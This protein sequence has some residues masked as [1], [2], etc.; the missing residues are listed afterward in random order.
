MTKEQIIE[1]ITKNTV[2]EQD[3]F[4]Y[5]GVKNIQGFEMALEEKIKE[6]KVN[7]EYINGAFKF[8]FEA[9]EQEEYNPLQE[10]YY[11]FSSLFP[12]LYGISAEEI[13]IIVRAFGLYK[14]M[15]VLETVL[16]NKKEVIYFKHLYKMYEDKR[17]NV[18]LMLQKS[19]DNFIKL[20]DTRTKDMDMEKLK[21]LGETVLGEMNKFSKT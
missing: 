12:A 11:F 15:M 6:P 20:V 19:L 18:A 13:N 3:L 5:Y 9:R 8:I 10:K 17:G 14:A 1:K 21:Q 4:E 7:I 16:E 2:T